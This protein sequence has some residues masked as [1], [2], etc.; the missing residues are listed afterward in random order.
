MDGNALRIENAGNPI[1]LENEPRRQPELVLAN[2]R[3][4]F[5]RFDRVLSLY[6]ML[7]ESF[8]RCRR[9][10]AAVWISLER[11]HGAGGGRAAR[12]KGENCI[13]G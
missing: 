7:P 1:E 2:P 3:T 13:P 8:W 6:V 9:A 12:S 5:S 4:S 11:L 10:V